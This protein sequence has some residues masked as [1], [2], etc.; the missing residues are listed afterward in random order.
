MENGEN[1]TR[2]QLLSL[3]ERKWNEIKKYHAVIVVPTGKKHSSGFALMALIGCNGNGEPYEIAAYCDD[4][5]WITEVTRYGLRCDMFYKNCCLRFHSREFCF[6]ISASLSTT[7]IK[8][9]KR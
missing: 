7:E 8:M 4:I 1:L 5:Q 9:I 2:K 6:Q 3:P